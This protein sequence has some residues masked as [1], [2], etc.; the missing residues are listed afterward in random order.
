MHEIIK[1]AAGA[2]SQWRTLWRTLLFLYLPIGLLFVGVGILSRVVEDASLQFFLRDIT[3]TGDLPFFAGFVSQLDAVL[4]SA[5]L[6]V[7]F[8]SLLLMRR[9]S[10]LAASKRF[11]LHGGILTAMLL[12]DDIFLFHEEVAPEYLHIGEKYVIGVYLITGIFFVI[13]NRDEI[14]S[15]E[16]LILFLALALFGMSIFLDAI[17]IDE[18]DL[19]YFWEQLEVFLEDGFKFAGIATWLT[20]F[21]RYVAQKIGALP[22]NVTL[23]K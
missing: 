6:T 17:P 2:R 21:V 12:L 23:E 13:S 16:Y 8:F 4:W 7:C 20:Y 18:F 1:L 19:R 9:N 14:L 10:G 3:A 15:S 22:D 5:S 11:L